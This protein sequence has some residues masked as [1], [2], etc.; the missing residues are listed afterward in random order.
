MTKQL[1][2][3]DKMRQRSLCID[4]RS[5]FEKLCDQSNLEAG[6]KAVK[7]NGGAPGID[8]VT[9]TKGSHNKIS[10]LANIG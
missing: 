2:T 6:F 7:K 3:K 5:L 9:I 1:K 8:G 10:G 4:E